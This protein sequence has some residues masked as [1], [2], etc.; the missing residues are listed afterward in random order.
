MGRT[1]A[2]RCQGGYKTPL[3]LRRAWKQS[4]IKCDNKNPPWAN[5]RTN[6]Q[7][8][9]NGRLD[10]F[11]IYNIS[12]YKVGQDLMV[13]RFKALNNKID[14]L[15]LNE[16]LIHNLKVNIDSSYVEDP[17]VRLNDKLKLK[18]FTF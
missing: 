10:K 5:E 15:W 18:T 3:L 1:W 12:N 9:F 7:Q 16:S 13:N 6:H 14:L 8:N 4:E 2:G 11:Q 17:L